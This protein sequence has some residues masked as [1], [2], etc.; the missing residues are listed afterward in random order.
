MSVQQLTVAVVD[1]HVAITE[2]VLHGLR[3]RMP[4]LTTA[5][6]FTKVSELLKL[7]AGS[8]D[9]VVLDISLGDGSDPAKNVAALCAQGWPVL[10]YTQEARRG[11]VADCLRAGANGIVGKN[12]SF[13]LLAT[14]IRALAAGKDYVNPAWATALRESMDRVRPQLSARELDV[15]RLIAAGMQARDIALTLEVG[16]STV[17]EY[18]RRI[19]TKYADSD[20]APRSMREIVLAAIDDGVLNAQTPPAEV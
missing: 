6:Q 14:A 9:V 20:K 3:A 13:N 17:K 8:V 7:K 15:L 5:L 19:R 16:D 11:V 12:E 4:E 1:D 18:C 2:G 10:L